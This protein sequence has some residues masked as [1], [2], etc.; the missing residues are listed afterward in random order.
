M[1][2]KPPPFFILTLD[3][4]IPLDQLA[5]HL[6]RLPSIALYNQVAIQ[7]LNA[8]SSEKTIIVINTRLDEYFTPYIRRFLADHGLACRPAII[9]VPPPKPEK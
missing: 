8:L 5:N 3:E 1:H 4:L 7:Q 6:E 9:D 2:G